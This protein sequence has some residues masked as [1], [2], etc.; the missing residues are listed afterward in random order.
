MKKSVLYGVLLGIFS[1]IWVCAIALAIL[2]ATDFLYR[3]DIRL[4]DIS[5]QTGLS[6]EVLLRNYHAILDYLIPFTSTAFTLPD[7]SFSTQGAF[8]FQECKAIFTG[9]Y[10]LGI[11]CLVLTIMLVIWLKKTHRFSAGISITASIVTVCLPLLI[12][13]AIAVNAEGSFTL[14]HQIFFRNDY[15]IFDVN[16][17]PV[18][19]ILPM[20][21]F[22]HCGIFIGLCWILCAGIWFVLGLRYNRKNRMS[23]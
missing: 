8:H 12:L 2:H 5:S 19:Q 15:W 13:I 14:F 20:D 16:T 22:I 1:L 9:V 17:D 7:F 11:L 3:I 23:K 18:I 21:F 4:L 6:E 10:L